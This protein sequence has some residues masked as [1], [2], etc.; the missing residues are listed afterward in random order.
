MRRY[1][2]LVAE[3][4]SKRGHLAVPRGR[5]LQVDGLGD[6]LGYN[7]S[8][9]FT[10]GY[11]RL[12]YVRVESISAD[13]FNLLVDPPGTYDPRSVAFREHA[14]G[15]WAPGFGP[16]FEGME[17]PFVTT[18]GD[19]IVLGGVVIDFSTA[20]RIADPIELTAPSHF[21]Y[22]KATPTVTT[23]F[24]RGRSLHELRLFATIRGMKDVRLA[25]TSNRRVVVATRPQG[26]PAGL[27]RIGLATIDSLDD[28]DQS[29]VDSATLVTNDVAEDVKMGPNELHALD[30]G[31]V[32]V[33]AHAA[34]RAPDGDL[35]YAAVAFRVDRDLSPSPVQVIATRD[36]WPAAEVKRSQVADVVFPS[37]IARHPDG[38]ATLIGGLSD[39]AIGTLEIP[40]PFV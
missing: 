9:P 37:G 12:M 26:G 38:T 30:N 7:P 36:D 24:Y 8:M 34:Y 20:R 35:S 5:I 39:G 18:I 25:E 21:D 19:E 14:G 1:S 27:G 3:Y 17:D 28:L 11:T 23:V 33:I 16:A 6:K 22:T 40:D 13:W 4:R 10:E 29:V 32:G 2:Q 31:A 15:T